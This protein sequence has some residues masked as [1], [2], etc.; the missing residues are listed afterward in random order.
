MRSH[1]SW[2]GALASSYLEKTQ[3]CLANTC[4]PWRMQVDTDRHFTSPVNSLVMALFCRRAEQ[5]SSSQ[6]GRNSW[7][8]ARSSAMVL[9]DPGAERCSPSPSCRPSSTESTNRKRDC[10]G[11]LMLSR[12]RR[13]HLGGE[14]DWLCWFGL[15]I[16]QQHQVELCRQLNLKSDTFWNLFAG[17]SF[18]KSNQFGVLV[19]YPVQTACVG[20]VH[21][22]NQ[23][24]KEKQKQNRTALLQWIRVSLWME[25][26]AAE[27]PTQDLPQQDVRHFPPHLTT[28]HLSATEIK[29]LEHL[30]NQPCGTKF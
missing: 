15:R 14:R 8:L 9:G 18:C 28:A 7:W 17:V 27:T 3:T 25:M 2:S 5:M 26:K 13:T 23:P 19:C 12:G 6:G 29:T 24:G 20:R 30:I 22:H 16:F 4:L 10:C 11:G 1:Y 21:L